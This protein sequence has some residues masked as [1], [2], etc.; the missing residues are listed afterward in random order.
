MTEDLVL[1]MKRIMTMEMKT[2]TAMTM[3]VVLRV[4]TSEILSLSYTLVFP[5]YLFFY[6]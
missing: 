6:H 4:H 1:T 5:L 2:M 3:W